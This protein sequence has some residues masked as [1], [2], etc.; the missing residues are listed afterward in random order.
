MKRIGYSLVLIFLLSCGVG[1]PTSDNLVTV[2]LKDS[3][4]APLNYYLLSIRDEA[5]VVSP[6]IEDRTM[7]SLIVHAEVIPFRKIATISFHHDANFWNVA[8]PGCGGAVFGTCVGGVIASATKSTSSDPNEQ[9]SRALGYGLV[10][11][12]IG[13]A[14]GITLGLILNDYDKLL[15]PSSLNETPQIRRH[16]IF[17][18]TQPPELQRIK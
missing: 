4:L 6:G 10:G 13:L 14:A 7:N 5:I 17:N 18:Y 16:A 8:L 1:G 11:E 12:L 3:T 15:Y 2:Q 9:L